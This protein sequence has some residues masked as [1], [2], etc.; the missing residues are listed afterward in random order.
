MSNLENDNN[1]VNNVS[2]I[3]SPDTEAMNTHLHLLFGRATRG[4]IEITGLGPDKR[5][6]TRFFNVDAT[7]D[8][9]EFAT[10]INRDPGCNVYVGAALRNDDVFPASAA[11]DTDFMAT[12]VVWADADDDQQVSAAK[13]AYRA[14]NVVPPVVVVTGRTPS[15][16]AQFWWPLENPI[17]DIDVLRGLLRGIASVLGT[18]P[19]VC[20]GKQLMRLAGGLAWPKPNKPGRV[21][22]RTE[23][24]VVDHAAREFIVEQLLTAFPP[25]VKSA[26]GEIADIVM[27]PTGALGLT[28]KVM[29]GREGYA[30]RL[31][32]AT[33]REL[34]GTTGS[35]PTADELYREAAPIFLARADQVRP[36]RG[37]EFLKQKCV[38]AIHAYNEGAIPGM[39]SLEEAVLGWA[40]RAKK[41]VIGIPIT[42][43]FQ[44]DI[45]DDRVAPKTFD[46]TA[47]SADAY[48]GP[49]PPIEWLCEGTIPL[50]APVLFASMGGLGKSFMALD[51][52]LTIAVG[53]ASSIKLRTILGGS[54]IQTGSVVILSA[55][56]SRDSIHRRLERID[57][58]R[59][60]MTNPERLMVV[61][62][63]DIGGPKPLVANDGK[64]LSLT[65]AFFS[66]QDELCAIPDLR[67]I[68]IDP[69]QAFVL[70]D[71]NADPAVGQFMWSAFAAICA[72][73]GATL[74]ACHHMR[75]D[76][77]AGITTADQAREAIRGSTA[78]V[79]GARLSYALWKASGEDAR[80]MC[81]RLD[82]EFE[83][84]RIAF[85]A[86]VKANDEANRTLQT[87]AREASG[88]LVDVTSS[89]GNGRVAAG[90]T[91][92]VAQSVV[93]EIGKA[94]IAAKSGHGEG[95]ALSP[96]SGERQAWKLLKRRA[97][98][99]DKEA[100]ST[101]E[102]W[103]QNGIIE[104][105]IVDPKRH[106]GALRHIKR[107]D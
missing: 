23:L 102:A 17:T 96:Q 14:A 57:P 104:M 25:I 2:P 3:L 80:D 44:E 58:Q 39:G 47:W 73:T 76:G 38:E 18:D 98:C 36:G 64:A 24:L 67:L 72:K 31:V 99:S 66:L 54:V 35:E 63:P 34:I 84:E 53:V 92:E 48:A 86:V 59:R 61:P 5:V 74:I 93:I 37:P 52:G 16:R 15:R 105:Q 88:L 49:A 9:A 33:L 70:A 12:Y 79:D 81:A 62:M 19:K 103:V 27:A 77:G 26:P 8:A 42:E 40:E 6:R 20:T 78:L 11:D 32:R 50:G 85:G 56:D 65:P 106:R 75:K 55:E 91:S 13:E 45:S 83:P 7:E 10:T 100:K 71:I 60:R 89:V 46:L 107:L 28:E 87:Y 69:L 30:F 95:Y 1:L 94:W 43:E 101:I 21:L 97:G 4:K 51:L 90:V 41:N 68:V 22:E 29:D 82:I